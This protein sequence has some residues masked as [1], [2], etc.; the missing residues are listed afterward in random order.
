MHRHNLPTLRKSLF[1][2]I[3]AAIV[4]GISFVS[5]SYAADSDLVKA[6][7]G[8]GRLVAYGDPTK[9]PV[10]IAGFSKLYPEIRVTSAGMGGYQGYNRHLN[11]KKAGKT[12]ADIIYT[13]EDA[14]VTA[15]GDGELQSYRPD[16]ASV[17]PDWAANPN[18]QYVVIHAVLCGILFNEV[19]M[20]GLPLPK[21]WTD[22]IAPPKEWKDLIITSDPRNSSMAFAVVAG[23]Y[24][25]Y[26]AEQA[27]T[28][29]KGMRSVN[30]ELSPNAGPQTAKLM[31][32]E[33]PLTPTFHTGYLAE[34]LNQGAPI[35]LVA[36][37]AGMIAQFT[38]MGITKEAPHPNA[39][40]LFVEYA[41]SPEGQTALTSS[42]AYS[43]RKDIAAPSGMPSFFETKLIALDMR[44]A[45]KDRKEIIEWWQAAL[46][47][48]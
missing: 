35:K 38:A 17:L 5:Q 47:I 30:Q 25:K 3:S 48:N 22:F 2:V 39:A 12:I 41:L 24:Q 21:D 36:P 8:E 45:L 46:G 44:K 32:G 6:A 1:A 34:M 11:E 15:S 14:M 18:Q 10:L 23:L 31:S 28:I 16:A 37:E 19:A 26:G 43:V 29:L 20:K 4:F 33:R 42:G 40:R 13:G 9:L 7:K 27:G